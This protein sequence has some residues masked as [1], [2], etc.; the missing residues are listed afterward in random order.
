M[1]EG[2]AGERVWP[3]AGQQENVVPRGDG[4]VEASAAER[5]GQQGRNID[6]WPFCLSWRSW[7][8]TLLGSGLGEWK[9]HWLQWLKKEGEEKVEAVCG[10]NASG[11]LSCE[12]PQ[13][14]GAGAKGNRARGWGKQE[15]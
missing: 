14:N 4:P 1:R 15:G 3:Q 12:E 7:T 11:E 9:L 2:P 13:R 5:L 6:R 8:S 10:D